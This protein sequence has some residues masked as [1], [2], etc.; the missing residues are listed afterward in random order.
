[1]MS[2]WDGTG[3]ACSFCRCILVRIQSAKAGEPPWQLIAPVDSFAVS[4]DYFFIVARSA[5]RALAKSM[6]LVLAGLHV[7]FR[8]ENRGGIATV[9]DHVAIAASLLLSDLHFTTHQR[10]PDFSTRVASSAVLT[11]FVSSLRW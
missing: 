7:S 2:N 9:D 5:F 10:V 3:K 1:M 11:N 6:K 4:C 8:L